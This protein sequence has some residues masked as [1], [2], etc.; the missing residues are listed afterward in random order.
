LSI[1]VSPRGY[2]YNGLGYYQE[3]CTSWEAVNDRLR[4]SDHFGKA[5]NGCA[6]LNSIANDIEKNFTDSLKRLQAAH[7]AIKKAVKWNDNESVYSSWE[8]LNI[9]YNKKIGNSADVNLMLILLLKKLN[10]EVYP[11]ALSTRDNG[12]LSPLYP[13]LDKFNY[14]IACVYLNGKQYL[15]DATEQN[16]P[17][18]MLPERCINLQGR[19]IDGKKSQWVDLLTEKKNKKFIQFDLKLE[20]NND[21]TG[22]LTK[23]NYEYASLDFRNTYEQFNSKEEYLKN[24][25][26][27]HMGLNVVNCDI[28]NL[29]SIYRP[30]QEIYEV[31][32]KNKVYSAGNL[33]Y[34]TP[35]LY[36]QISSNP[37][38]TVER[39]Y[40]V[41]FIYPSEINYILKL[42]LP[43]GIQVEQLPAPSSMKLKDGTATFQYQVNVS[44]NI[45]QLNYKFALKKSIFS[46]VEYSDLRAFFSEMVKKHAEQIVLKKI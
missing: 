12:F 29:D 9:I 30:L 33:L 2:G 45:I 40:P 26:S 31:N 17:I 44:N 38:K 23:T 35:L 21:L 46:E 18:D 43:E 42:N 16:L 4:E 11:V 7:G 34:I 20:E 36:E 13:S 41:D 5:L 27:L 28:A 24:F 6:S 22:S 15:L 25:E 8:N 1:G 39:K 37:F 3:F 10:F 14:V 32:I 19:L